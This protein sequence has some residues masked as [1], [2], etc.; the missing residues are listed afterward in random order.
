MQ[1]ILKAD[2]KGTG[3]AGELVKVSDGYARNFLFPKK[4]AIEAD[5][6]ALND[7]KNKQAAQEHHVQE[8]IAENRAMAQKID[9]KTVVVKAKAGKE[10]KLFGSVTGKEIAAEINAQFGVS[11]DKRKIKLDTAIKAF[12]SYR[13]VVR[14]THSVEAKMSVQVTE[15]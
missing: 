3:K 15:L 4:L 6:A 7:L 12:G 9:G 2:V 11:V 8:E 14:F 5:A 1:V 10:G 13:A